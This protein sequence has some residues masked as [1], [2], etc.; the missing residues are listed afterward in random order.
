MES[1]QTLQ[2]HWKPSRAWEEQREIVSEM[3]EKQINILVNTTPQVFRVLNSGTFQWGIA[4]RLSLYTFCGT[5]YH[6]VLYK[7]K[8]RDK[9]LKVHALLHNEFF[10]FLFCKLLI[11]SEMGPIHNASTIGFHEEVMVSMR[12]SLPKL[13]LWSPVSVKQ[14]P[15]RFNQ[16]K[17][18][19]SI[20][21][22]ILE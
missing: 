14:F 19:I 4:R 13:K 17:R 6:Y 8:T 18:V 22:W 7:G 9:G 16:S 15:S 21:S 5:L 20:F 10:S 2:F 3:T 1:R 11:C 12:V